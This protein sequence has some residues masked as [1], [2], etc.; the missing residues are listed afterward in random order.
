MSNDKPRDPLGLDQ[1][2]DELPIVKTYFGKGSNASLAQRLFRER[3]AEYKR[4]KQIAIAKKL[5]AAEKS[6]SELHAERH[7]TTELT[8][9][10]K[11]AVSVISLEEA[12]KYLRGTGQESRDNYANL[13]KNDP[14]KA[15]LV[16][17][18]GRVYGFID[19]NAGVTVIDH[20][21]GA[22]LRARE[23]Q[24]RAID[25]D[26]TLTTLSAEQCSSLK[27]PPGT[28]VT[29]KEFGRLCEERFIRDRD[30]KRAEQE[31]S[32]QSAPPAQTPAA[33]PAKQDQPKHGDP[34]IVAN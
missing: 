24:Q 32:A 25:K 17:L 7:Q 2:D 19:R 6:L 5:I 26:M 30:A 13:V 12:S 23:Q 34:G 28:R 22:Q 10:E 9:D 15:K 14:V 8:A 21:H 1:H 29:A 31:A 33:A 27:V 3:P 16:Q 18:A 20:S 11:Y 4:L